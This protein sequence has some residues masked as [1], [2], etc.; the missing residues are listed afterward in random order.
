MRRRSGFP[1]SPVLFTF[2]VGCLAGPADLGP[3]ENASNPGSPF[4]PVTPPKPSFDFAAIVDPDHGAHVVADLHAAG[5]GLKLVGHTGVQSI[6]PA[7]MRGSITQIDVWKGYAAVAGFQEGPAFVIVDL[8]DPAHPTPLSHYP[9]AAQGWTVRFSDDGQY[10]FYGCQMLP[11]PYLTTGLV[12]GDCRDPEALH[13][14]GTPTGGV[15]VFDVSDK[16]NPRFIDFLATPGSHNLQQQSINGTDFVFTANTTILKFDRSAQKLVQVAH[17]PGTHDA[18]VVRHPLTGDWLLYT[19]TQQLAIYNVTNPE[20]PQ[21][22][23]NPGDWKDGTGWHDQVAFP[24]LV[25]GRALLALAGENFVSTGAAAG[26]G[27]PDTITLVDITDPAQPKKLGTWKPPFAAKLPWASY[28]F[29][30]HEMAATPQ[31]QLA[32]AWYH[33]GAWVIDLSTQERQAAPVTLAAYQPHVAMNVLPSTFQQTPLPYVPYVW[34][35]A[36]DERGYLV[37]PDIHTGVYVLEPAWGLHPLLDS[38]A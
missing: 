1:V 28:A 24:Y 15:G 5:H 18:T 32:V 17:V 33:G 22:V 29:S 3:V 34:S 10:L 4:A 16:A 7:G 23:L 37:V 19:G 13:V 35:A 12:K 20:D 8:R 14:P 30:A 25:D 6:L 11:P 36:W 31:G 2:L 21:I 26:D 27:V 9:S 38:G